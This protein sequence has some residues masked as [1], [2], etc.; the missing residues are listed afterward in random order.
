[1]RELEEA[2][3]VENIDQFKADL[4]VDR[5]ASDPN[6]VNA[7]LPPDIVNQ[8]RVLAAQVQFRS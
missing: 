8:M 2:G 7:L 3:L 6:R 4:I 1:M 5:D